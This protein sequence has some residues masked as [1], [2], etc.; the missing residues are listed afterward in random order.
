MLSYKGPFNDNGESNLKSL[1]HPKVKVLGTGGTIASMGNSSSQTAGYTIG[2]TIEDLMSKIPELSPV[3]DVDFE[4]V[5]NKES[6]KFGTEDILTLHKK[7]ACNIS[8]Y[9]GIVITHG[10]DTMEESAFFLQMTIDTEKPVVFCGSMRPTSAISCDGPMNLYQAIVIAANK[11]SRGR[12]VL[13]SLN[14]KI[15][16]GFYVTKSNANSLD[17]FK[18]VDQGYVGCFVDD[19]I[20]YFFPPSKPLGVTYF[21]IKK[22]LEL[23]TLPEVPI[24]YAHQGFND[25]LIELVFEHLQVL[26]LVMAGLGAGCLSDSTDKMLADISHRY[27]ECPIVYSRRTMDGMVPKSAL[28]MIHNNNRLSFSPNAVASGY[29]NP[30]KA[31]ILLQLCL[32]TNMTTREVKKTFE[33]IYG[34]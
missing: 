8:D 20:H 27:N 23:G 24:L 4:Q 13:V 12:G 17:T 18:A 32:V 22:A 33:R 2:L 30:Q 19:E 31:R 14:D 15:G 10:T 26:G 9:D 7:V 6:N 1:N 3:C 16:S 28:P 21:D 29:L 34:G 25:K 11:A 5:L